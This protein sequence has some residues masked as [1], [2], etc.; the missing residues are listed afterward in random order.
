VNKK[1]RMKVYTGCNSTVWYF[2]VLGGRIYRVDKNFLEW[3]RTWED[4]Q[5]CDGEVP[6]VGY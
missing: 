5:H 4:L 3:F 2:K 6:F 1:I